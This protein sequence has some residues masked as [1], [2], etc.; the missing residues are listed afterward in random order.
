MMNYRLWTLAFARVT[1]R[2]RHSRGSGNPK[3]SSAEDLKNGS[4][5]VGGDDRKG[6]SF[7]RKRESMVSYRLWTLAS[8]RVT[9]KVGEGDRKKDVIPASSLSL[10]AGS[11]VARQVLRLRGEEGGY[12]TN[13]ASPWTGGVA[14][15]CYREAPIYAIGKLWF[16]LFG[17]LRGGISC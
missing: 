7:P 8:A 15:L 17:K 16:V 2:R 13:P 10:F 12:T 3:P 9:E 11:R 4:P 5:L 6:T 1:E 14:D